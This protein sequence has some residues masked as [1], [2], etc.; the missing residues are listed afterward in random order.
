MVG[1][2]TS[3]QD[4]PMPLTQFLICPLES[5]KRCSGPLAVKPPLHRLSERLGLLMDFFMHEVG[6]PPLTLTYRRSLDS[7]GS[8][9]GGFLTRYP[10]DLKMITIECG[11]I[12]VLEINNLIHPVCNGIN[13]TG[14]ELP[15]IAE[16]HDER[17]SLAS[18]Y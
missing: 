2:S 11:D 15:A 9:S 7:H 10:V 12:P 17:T 16:S 3:S 8:G 5:A 18:R 14:E 4:D 1:R 13:V 6:I